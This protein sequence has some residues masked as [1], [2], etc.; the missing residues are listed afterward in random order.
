MNTQLLERLESPSLLEWAARSPSL[1]M[2]ELAKLANVPQPELQ[3]LL[4][5]EAYSANSFAGFARAVLVRTLGTTAGSAKQRRA[6]FDAE[7]AGW[8]AMFDSDQRERAGDIWDSIAAEL[9]AN[10]EWAPTSAEDPRLVEL[11]VDDPFERS[12]RTGALAHARSRVAAAIAPATTHL[13]RL[14]N[15]EPLPIGHTYLHALEWLDA[16]VRAGGF[17]QFY[18]HGGGVELPAVFEALRCIERRDVLSIVE[19]SL[20]YG[21][22]RKRPRLHPD[23][24]D[25]PPVAKFASPR[26]WGQLDPVYAASNFDPSGVMGA[27]L[28]ARV[29]LFEPAWT[30][31]SSPEDGRRW[32]I[33]SN[34]YINEVEIVFA[35]GTTL[36]RKRKFNN[37]A[38][39]KADLKVLIAEQ[40]RD[41]FV[42]AK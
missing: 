28:E 6:R 5:E 1:A 2:A 4:A 24:R 9:D 14:K 30:E 32:R 34:G 22:A 16:E 33:R 12:A 42:R 3:R 19:E 27:L 38:D 8:I 17:A 13:G 10:P 25:Q 36:Q 7:R 26:A 11:F 41:G 29:E 15:L 18:Q 23:V 40:Q 35:D 31:L 21:R 39:T 20:A 37:A